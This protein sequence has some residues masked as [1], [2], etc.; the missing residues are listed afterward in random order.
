MRE[1]GDDLK[2]NWYNVDFTRK[3]NLKHEKRPG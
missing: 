2:K 1:C 3:T